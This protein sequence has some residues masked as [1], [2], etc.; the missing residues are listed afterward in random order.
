MHYSPRC[1][2]G[3]GMFPVGQN[4]RRSGWQAPIFGRI[5]ISVG[6]QGKE[7]TG[8]TLAWTFTNGELERRVPR[9][10]RRTR[11]HTADHPIPRRTSISQPP[12]LAP[13]SGQRRGSHAGWVPV[14]HFHAGGLEVK[15]RKRKKKTL[16]KGRLQA[17]GLSIGRIGVGRRFRS[18]AWDVTSCLLFFL[19][20]GVQEY[21]MDVCTG[22]RVV[23]CGWYYLLPL[24]AFCF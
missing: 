7:W 4:W 2:F 17:S 19:C 1:A 24:P 22:G 20:F 8:R 13:R 6:G 11:M 3:F 15:L 16:K 10:H 5:D 18:T 21:W 23:A 14:L 12:S 9:R